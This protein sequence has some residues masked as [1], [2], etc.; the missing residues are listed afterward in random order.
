MEVVKRFL[1]GFFLTTFILLS[2]ALP[3]RAK[4]FSLQ[5]TLSPITSLLVS[6]GEKVQYFFAF[7]PSAKVKVLE[8]QAQRRL[9]IAQN[10]TSKAENSIKE[11]Q[12]I[13]DKQNTL[14]DKIDDDTLKQVQ[15]QTLEEQQTLAKI[16]NNQK[17]IVETVRTVNTTVVEGIK[18][19][20]TLK[21][22]TTAGEAFEQKATI[23][24]APGTGPGGTATLVIEGQKYAPGTS[25]GGAAGN[26][27]NNVVIQGGGGTGGTTVQGSNP[28]VVGGSGET[29]TGGTTVSGNNPG[30]ATGTS[31][32]G[33][34]T[35]TVVGQ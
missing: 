7:T 4:A 28:S 2:L 13:K 1:T 30:T 11:Y 18:N 25:S 21:E 31:G 17:D 29:G 16:G 23:V 8:N 34:G 10:D 3:A 22:G 5:Q 26:N 9:T 6:V 14:L 12:D 33:T 32:G 27:T 24:Y 15:E 20:V 35:Q 19:V